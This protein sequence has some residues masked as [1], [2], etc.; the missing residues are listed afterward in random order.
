M[1]RTASNLDSE[2]QLAQRVLVDAGDA[3]ADLID[4]TGKVL[5]LEAGV[6]QARTYHC[7]HLGIGGKFA[8]QVKNGKHVAHHVL[9]LRPLSVGQK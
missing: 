4:V 2:F 6:L 5:G 3:V 8:F 1:L 7:H 9:V